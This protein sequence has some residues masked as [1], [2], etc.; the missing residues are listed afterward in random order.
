[1]RAVYLCFFIAGFSCCA[2]SADKPVPS[3]ASQLSQ[4]VVGL[5]L[6]LVL[7]GAISWLAKRF[8]QGGFQQNTY[9]KIVSAM[10]LGTRERL[11]IVDA[12]GTHI[13]LGVTATNIQT[14]HIFDE[15]VVPAQSPEQESEFAKK[16]MGILQGKFIVQPSTSSGT[17][18]PSN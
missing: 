3:T 16:L 13:L 17:N 15:P 11:L 4:V 8:S 1:M 2:W 9:L 6:I 14:L 18:K 5:C 10:P 12:G 7:I